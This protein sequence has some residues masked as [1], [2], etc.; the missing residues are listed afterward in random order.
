MLQYL[1]AFLLWR[2][3]GISHDTLEQCRQGYEPAC[4]KGVGT[5]SA[6]Q[7]PRQKQE[8]NEGNQT[9]VS[10][11]PSYSQ[12]RQDQDGAWP[13]ENKKA[14]QGWRYAPPAVPADER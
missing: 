9:C 4:Q 12:S 6:E 7:Q 2:R 1:G 3:W 10:Q 8:R 11:Q 5:V 13:S 14:A